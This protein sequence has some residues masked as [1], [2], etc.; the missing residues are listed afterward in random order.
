ML[1]SCNFRGDG[2]EYRLLQLPANAIIVA[3][4]IIAEASLPYSAMIADQDE[5]TLLLPDEVCQEFRNRLKMATYSDVVYRLITID[6]VLEPELVGLIARVSR[7]LAEISIPV[8][9]FA[10]YSRDHFMVPTACYEEAL[11]ALK[12]LQESLR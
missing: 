2:A 12:S 7:A 1:R 3:A 8:L 9:V 6:A 10:A 4:G 11:A 5:V